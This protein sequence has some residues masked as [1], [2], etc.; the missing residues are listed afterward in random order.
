[1]GINRIIYNLCAGM[2]EA[3]ETIEQCV[4]RELYEETGLKIDEM[5]EIL[6]PSYSAVAISDIKTHIAILKA[7][8]DFEDHS[9]DNEEISAA[10][11]SKED[12]TTLLKT[13]EFSSRAQIIA[14][15]FVMGVFDAI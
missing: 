5:I 10:F 11:Y 15:F 8:G 4:E 7:T 12:V 13:E 2:S 3:A 6:P 14:Y 1:M 9:S